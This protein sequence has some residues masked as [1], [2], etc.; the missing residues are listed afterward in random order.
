[1]NQLVYIDESGDAGFKIPKGSTPVFVIVLVIFD[2]PIDAEETAL[3]IKKY[4]RKLRKSDLFEFKFNKSSRELR[5]GFFEEI[6]N[7]KFRIRTIVFNKNVL[8]SE[9][10]RSSKDKF[11]S[12]AVKEVLKNNNKTISNAKIYIDGLGER[13]FKK[14]LNVYLRQNLNTKNQNILSHIKF[15][16]SKKNVL[17][18]LA[19]MVAGAIRRSHDHSNEDYSVY[20]QKIKK[21][22][23]DEWVFK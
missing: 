23:E 5:I 12:Y 15:V 18:Q 7:C 20:K 22:I 14:S 19:D 11:Y 21:K 6:K 1:M 17:I 8:Y 9:A 2:D 10:L 4:R 13:T 3:I 16:D